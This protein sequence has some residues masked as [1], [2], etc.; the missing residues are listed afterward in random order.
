MLPGLSSRTTMCQRQAEAL[1]SIFLST[2]SHVPEEFVQLNRT[3]RGLY[4]AWPTPCKGK[5]KYSKQ[6]IVT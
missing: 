1:L 4:H 6:E 2:L 3:R 5:K